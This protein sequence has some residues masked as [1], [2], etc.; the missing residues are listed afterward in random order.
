MEKIFKIEYA[1]A[2]H[3]DLDETA[4]YITNTLCAP[5][6]AQNLLSKIRKTIENLKTFPFSGTL[7]DSQDSASISIRWVRAE[8]YM[9]FYTVN[10]ADE[11]VYVLRILYGS[12]NYPNVL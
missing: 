9:I 3:F 2:V 10:E 6:A 12:S 11:C 8:N 4:E 1:P 5:Q 7:V